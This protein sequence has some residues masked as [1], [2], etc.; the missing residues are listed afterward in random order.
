MSRYLDELIYQHN[1]WTVISLAATGGANMDQ[2][3]KKKS[4]VV[5]KK[6]LSLLNSVSQKYL[7]PGL[8]L[9]SRK[10]KKK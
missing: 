3:I 2:Q 10:N 9:R 4:D 6:L 8:K 7:R 1:W 5:E